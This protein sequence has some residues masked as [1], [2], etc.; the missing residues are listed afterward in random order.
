MWLAG[1]CSTDE[2]HEDE[3]NMSTAADVKTTRR[4]QMPESRMA[5]LLLS[6]T[7]LVLALVIAYPL[8]AAVYQSLFASRSG[9][10]EDGFVTEGETFVGL[11]NYVDIFTGPAGERFWN[12]FWNTTYFTFVTVALE[13]VLGVC[14]ALAMNRAFKGRAFLRASI[15][16]P[17]A[18]PTAVS[19]LLWR[20]IFQSQG[21]AN[22]LLGKE[23]LWT[24][25]GFSAQMAI[26]I[27][28]VW[29]TAPF[30]GLLTLAGMQII[31]QE[32]YEA[33]RVDGASRWRQIWTITLPIVK[34]TLL[35]A[36]LFRMLDALRMFDLPFVLIGPGKRSVETL[37]MLAWEESNQLRYGTASAFVVVLF[38]YVALIAYAFIQLLGADITGQREQRKL[39][40]D[41]EKR[42]KQNSK[43]AEAA[44]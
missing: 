13:T 19:G 41:A 16:I 17:W 14:L 5:G 25:E 22:D 18:I 20:W 38:L 32:I 31:P 11:G 35:V 21:I 30:V 36:V 28:E 1:P 33:A 2:D 37:S 24:A 7:L 26:I 10:D 27:A 29:K 12:A 6:P 9:V 44:R 42:R 43:N 8:L 39:I 34:P 15:L 4:R 3:T 40:R 23:I